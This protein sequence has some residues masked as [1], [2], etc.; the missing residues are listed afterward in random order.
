MFTALLDANVL[1]PISLADTMLRAAEQE[2]YR[3]LWSQ[4]VIDEA[5][6]ALRQA[7]PD[8]SGARVTA[9]FAAMREAFPAAMVTE[10][11]CL[12]NDSPLPDPN[13]RHVLAAA[14]LGGADLIVTRNLKDFPADTLSLFGLAAVGADSFLRDLL[15]L[16][17]VKMLE[18]VRNQVAAT[19]QP[20]RKLNDV[21]ISLGL[22]GAPDFV[23]DTRDLL[24]H[25][26]G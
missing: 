3:P 24:E 21:L 7:R 5:I 13:D 11:E 1:V 6:H 12:I 25:E 26:Q 19:Q 22:A 18:V 16:F 2:L 10:F 20:A 23:A 9:R 15:D 17:P 8:I 4:I 14:R